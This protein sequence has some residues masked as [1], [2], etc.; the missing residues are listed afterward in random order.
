MRALILLAAVLALT[1]TALAQQTTAPAPYVPDWGEVVRPEEAVYPQVAIHRGIGGQAVICCKA[2][3]GLGVDCTLQS[4]TPSDAGFGAAALRLS[5]RMRL[6]AA[7]HADL[8]ARPDTIVQVTVGFR[9]AQGH[10]SLQVDDTGYCA[11]PH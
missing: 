2:G 11:A 4:E 5:H 10:N 8:A 6:T 3:D 1:G 9:T 7:S